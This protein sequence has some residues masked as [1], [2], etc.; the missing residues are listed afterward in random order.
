MGLS[1]AFH[2]GSGKAKGVNVAISYGGHWAL[3]HGLS[4]QPSPKGCIVALITAS[5]LYSGAPVAASETVTRT[6]ALG[7]SMYPY[8]AAADGARCRIMLLPKPASKPK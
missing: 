1:S 2:V 5:T 7:T 8:T 3:G 6:L 4:P